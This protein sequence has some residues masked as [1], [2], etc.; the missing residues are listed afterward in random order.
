MPRVTV[1]IPTLHG[2]ELL[3]RCLASLAQQTFS[4]FHVVVVNNGGRNW[5]PP[6][7]LCGA[8]VIEAG[9]NLGYGGALA[10]AWREF[11]AEY[12][13]AL[14]DDTELEADALGNMVAALDRDPRLGSVAPL[15]LLRETAKVD[16]AGLAIA[17]DGSSKQRGGSR[18]REQFAQAGETLLASGCAALYRASA[19]AETGGF[20]EGFFLYCEDTDLGLRLRRAGWVC[21]FQPSAVVHHFYSASSGG[22]SSQKVY[23]AERNR[24]AV[25]VKNLPWDWILLSPLWT[26]ARYIHHAIALRQGSGYPGQTARVSSGPFLAAIA[27]AHLHF[28]GWIP[29]LL[30]ERRRISAAARLSPREFR[31][32]L[33]H[34]RISVR[35][36]AGR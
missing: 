10:L 19:L 17:R 29:R 15:I 13:A 14:N 28:L 21:S 8:R 22:G 3:T 35:E 2:G 4:E 24:L 12:L 18:P 30:R 26:L 23:F 11:P 20:D 16:S 27:R 5:S 32:L 7:D 1:A 6:A 31:R 34:Y 33:N 9:N 36:V 25:L